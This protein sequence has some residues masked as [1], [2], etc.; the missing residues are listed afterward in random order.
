M[1]DVIPSD[2]PL[3]LKNQ[4]RSTRTDIKIVRKQTLGLAGEGCKIPERKLYMSS[5]S[6]FMYP[7]TDIQSHISYTWGTK[8]VRYRPTCAKT[9]NIPTKA[10]YDATACSLNFMT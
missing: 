3:A 9:D 6:H 4:Y 10:I 5:S 1:L 2:K 8:D 7:H